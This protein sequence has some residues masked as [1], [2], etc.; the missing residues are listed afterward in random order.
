MVPHV[1]KHYWFIG[2]SSAQFEIQETFVEDPDVLAFEGR[3][4]DRGG[5]PSALPPLTHADFSPAEQIQNLM[6]EQVA[7]QVVFVAARFEQRQR[8]RLA[9][10]AIGIPRFKKLSAVGSHQE[11]LVRGAFVDQSAQREN[12]RKGS[13]GV[14]QSGWLG[15]FEL[16][17]EACKTVRLEVDRVVPRQKSVARFGK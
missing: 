15:P 1:E 6:H 5:H 7:H 16:F 14:S 3:E 2:G 17:A 8:A 11:R 9:V 12:P 4:I 13:E 10:V